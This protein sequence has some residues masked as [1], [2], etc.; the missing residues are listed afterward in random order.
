[1][2]TSGEKLEYPKLQQELVLELFN[3]AFSTALDTKS[4]MIW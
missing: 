4:L 2:K 1:M 3:D